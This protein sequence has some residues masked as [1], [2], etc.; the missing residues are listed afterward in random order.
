[1]LRAVSASVGSCTPA[2]SLDSNLH[3]VHGQL[4]QVGTVER[5]HAAVPARAAARNAKSSAFLKVRTSTRT[6]QLLELWLGHTVPEN[7]FDR[8][9]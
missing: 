6:L 1:M 7:R 8:A 5:A 9:N 3:F 4:E 2:C